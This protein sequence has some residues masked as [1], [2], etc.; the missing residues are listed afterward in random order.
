MSLI[1]K[2]TK[3]IK[4]GGKKIFLRKLITLTNIILT[5]GDISVSPATNGANLGGAVYVNGGTLIAINTVLLSNKAFHG[6][7]LYGINNAI[8]YLIGSTVTGSDATS[9]GGGIYVDGSTL[10]LTNR[11]NIVN[12]T[13]GNS[14]GG[15]YTYSSAAIISRETTFENNYCNI[16]VGHQITS[17]KNRT[18]RYSTS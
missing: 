6:G 10:Q 8:M 16:N 5:L 9:N 3:E 2:N 7:S 4:K 11:S 12:N 15:I 1:S 17:E 13:A 18:T 14:G